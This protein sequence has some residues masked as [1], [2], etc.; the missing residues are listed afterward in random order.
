MQ[1]IL[2]DNGSSVDILFIS[3]FDKIK[4]GRDKCRDRFNRFY[5][6]LV[7][8]GGSLP[9]SLTNPLGWIKLHLTWGVKPHQT[10]VWHDLIVVDCLTPYNV[11][12]GRPTLGKIKAITSIYHLMMKFPTPTGICEV[13]GDQRTASQC[14]NTAM[15]ANPALKTNSQLQLNIDNAEMEIQMHPLD[16]EKT[17]FI[18]ERGLYCYKVMLLGL[19][20]VRAMYQRLVNKMFKE[21]IEKMIEVYIGYMLV[22]SLKAIDHIAHLEETFGI[23]RS[24]RIMINLSKW[25][26][27]VD[28][29]STHHGCRAGLVL[30]TPSDE[31]MEYA[32]RIGFK[33]TNNE[34][35]YEALLARLRVATD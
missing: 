35:V 14:F 11:I 6:P 7:R 18:M 9:G 5:I 32:I 2:N 25:K 4:I 26:L 22:K 1:R 29:S 23:L 24:H 20:N 16:V 30:Q 33:A 17:S 13:K 21:M 19:K 3:A 34:A 31:Q 12:L 27:F 15:K 28:G 8:F 10:T